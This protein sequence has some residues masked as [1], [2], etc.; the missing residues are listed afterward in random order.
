M[1]RLTGRAALVTGAARGIGLAV[2]RRLVEEGA[3]VVLTDIRDD[4]GARAASALGDGAVYRHLDV[5]EA[6]DWAQVVAECVQRH[7]RLDVL[8]NNAGITGFES[9]PGAHDPEHVS[10]E[11]WRAVMATNL[12]GVMLGCQA[13]IGAMRVAGTGSG[14]GSGRGSI[15]NIG[16][17]SGVVGIPGAAAYAASKAAVRNHTKSVALWCAGQGLAIRCNVVQPAAVLTPLWEPMLGTGPERAANIA[18]A[19]ADAPLRRFGTPEEVAAL[20]A[21]LASDESAYCTGSEF[22][23]DGGLLAGSAVSG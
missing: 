5:R 2:A 11:A 21:Y 9:H 8:V 10:L 15:I 16:S 7:G 4:D 17:R 14:C 19:V 13:A 3:Q 6:A 12:E 18:A 20:V 1:Q 23:I 22:N